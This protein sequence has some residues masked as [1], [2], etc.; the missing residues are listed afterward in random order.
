[1]AKYALQFTE[2]MKGFFTLREPAFERGAELGEASGTSIMFH[3][4]IGTDDTYRF[5][6]ER[7]HV[8]VARGWVHCD[9]LGGRLPVERGVFN[10]FV[11]WDADGASTDTPHSSH[12]RMLYRLWFSDS[13]G[14]PFTF[15]GFKEIVH[16]D[17][18]QVW[19]ETS[20]LYT[21][22][23]AGHVEADEE[24]A[25]D[26]VGAGIVHILKR[27]FAKQLTTFR[28]QGPSLFGRLKAFAAFGQLFAGQ[29]WDVFAPWKKRSATAGGPHA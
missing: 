17:P 15:S 29:L 5:I 19:P 26:V 10:L 2:E 20:T 1:M 22:V 21:K 6:E 13:V 7:D 24:A 25:A 4:T 23:F 8:G 27:D 28:V 18:T 12:K 14:H 11:D 16:N 9:V 3:L